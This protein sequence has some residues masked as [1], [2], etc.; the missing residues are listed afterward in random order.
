MS[1]WHRFCG[2]VLRDEDGFGVVVVV[3]KVVVAVYLLS[4][5]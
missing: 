2:C 4:V 5:G 3:V 1:E